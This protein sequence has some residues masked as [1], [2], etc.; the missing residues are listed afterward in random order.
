[1][2]ESQQQETEEQPGV[3][4]YQYLGAHSEADRRRRG[5]FNRIR[6]PSVRIAAFHTEH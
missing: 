3:T 2:A 4:M 5:S 6:I 1:M